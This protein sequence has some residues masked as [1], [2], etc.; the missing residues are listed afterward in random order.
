[1]S[2]IDAFASSLLEEAKRLLE[3]AGETSEPDAERAYL[4]S[5]L[6]L[7]FCSLEAHVNSVADEIA[8]RPMTTTHSRGVL[9]ERRVELKKGEFVLQNSPQ[10]SRLMDRIL[11][12][13]RLGPKPNLSGEWHGRLTTATDLRNKLT[14]PKSVPSLSAASVKKAIEAVIE[15]LDELYIAVYK[16]RFPAAHRSLD[17]KLTF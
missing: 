17:S 11:L 10:I 4:H 7:A 16:S 12:L 6:L 14:H 8:A 13:H 9:L 15:T 3:K 2:E 5:A 1:M